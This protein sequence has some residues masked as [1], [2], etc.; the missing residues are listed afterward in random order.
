ML[1]G[2]PPELRF[3]RRFHLGAFLRELWA[4][5]ELVRTLG[6]RDLRARYKQAA[7]GFS[8]AVL[9]PL[10]YMVVFTVFFQRVADVETGDV[11]YALFAYLGLLP[12]TLF[13]SCVSLGGLSLVS[14]LSL[15][16][17]VYCP[18]E[19]FP[20]ASAG[21]AVTDT[22]AASLVL[23]ILFAVHTYAPRATV[24]WVP[25]LLAV[26]LAFTL[27]VTLAVSAV[28]VYLRDLRHLIP[29]I[30]QVGLFATPVAYGID[31]VPGSARWVYALA[32]PLAPVI[33][34]YRRT[35]LYGTAP[36]WSLLGLGACS[37]AVVLVSGYSLF[38]RLETGFADVA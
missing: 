10:V 22:V 15:L 27:G 14:N 36:D 17:K 19:V 16:N 8:W 2:P 21:V 29:I 5:R 12:W 7:L 11:P 23:G 13:S 20:L 34:G 28:V 33:D 4:A 38:K 26:Q 37:A 9:T 30:L 18:R 35:V 31:A 32:N 3:R 6:E 1:D 24:V 25:V